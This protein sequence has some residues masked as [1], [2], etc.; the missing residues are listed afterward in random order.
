MQQEHTMANDADAISCSIQ[1]VSISLRK[2]KA[3]SWT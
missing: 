2:T 1:S 3:L